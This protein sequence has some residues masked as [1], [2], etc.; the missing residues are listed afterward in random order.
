M[1]AAGVGI[2]VGRGKEKY[3]V[4]DGE[5]QDR[6]EQDRRLRRGRLKCILPQ[7]ILLTE[8]H[9]I[10]KHFSFIYYRLSNNCICV[11]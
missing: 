11:I 5:L 4:G 2:I 3:V 9:N 6:V 10:V 7:F 1:V 8:N